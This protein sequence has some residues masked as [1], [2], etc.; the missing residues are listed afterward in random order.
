MIRCVSLLDNVLALFT[1]CPVFGMRVASP[2][3][4]AGKPLAMVCSNQV[5]WE[6]SSF[7]LILDETL[8]LIER[9]RP[10]KQKVSSLS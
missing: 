6:V 3:Q 1:N 4:P 5:I 9:L 8:A 2:Y 7:L 10:Q